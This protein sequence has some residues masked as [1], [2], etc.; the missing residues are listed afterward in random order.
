MRTKKATCF[1]AITLECQRKSST[2]LASHQQLDR[3][4]WHRAFDLRVTITQPTLC[5]LVD[6]LRKEQTD[7]ELLVEDANAGV[8]LPPTKKKYEYVTQRLKNIVER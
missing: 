1:S 8:A 7:N 2:R 3:G 5:L 6:R 4:R